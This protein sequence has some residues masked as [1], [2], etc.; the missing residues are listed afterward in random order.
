MKNL[1]I[2]KQVKFDAKLDKTVH[3]NDK[4]KVGRIILL[5]PFVSAKKPHR[6]A[7][8][9]IPKIE[10]PPKSPFSDDVKFSSHITGRI[11]LIVN[12]SNRVAVNI[13]P[14]IPIKM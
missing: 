4:N 7:L 2:I 8:D 11:K 10:I 14:E 5:L 13:I 3:V 1:R 6:C 12:V 9:I